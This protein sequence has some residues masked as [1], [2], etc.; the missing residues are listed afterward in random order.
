MTENG[1][2][3]KVER[4]LAWVI[5][6]KGEQ[7]AGCTACKSFGQG[8]FEVVALNKRGAKPGDNVEIEINPKHV[9]KYAVIVFMLPVLSLIIGYFLGSSYLT[10]IGLSSETA[11]IFGSLGLLLISFMGIIGYDRMVSKSQPINAQINRIL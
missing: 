6:V 7:C 10:S 1:V 11:G 4:D 2:V 9:V 8:S 3:K 5:T